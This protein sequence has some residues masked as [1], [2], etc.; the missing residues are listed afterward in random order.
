MDIPTDIPTLINPH[1]QDYI[2]KSVIYTF[3]TKDF[4]LDDEKNILYRFPYSKNTY[5]TNFKYSCFNI[6]KNQQEHL[7]IGIELRT[8]D[9]YKYTIKSME[10]LENKKWY[11]TVWPIPS[12]YTVGTEACIDFKIKPPS[13][14]KSIYNVVISLLGFMDLY[15][16]NN[17]YLLL[18]PFDTYQF[19]FSKFENGGSIYNVEHEDYI[20]DNINTSCII[21]MISKY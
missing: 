7:E 21:P 12:I 2:S 19:I 9:G 4:Y 13:D 10:D 11:D 3:S 8:S 5:W 15:P 6:T 18:S 17:T 14:N 1:I 16:N 20:R